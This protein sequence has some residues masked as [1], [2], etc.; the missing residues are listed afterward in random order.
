MIVVGCEC[1]LTVEPACHH[2]GGD[3]ESGQ[4]EADYRSHVA[5]EALEIGEVKL[6]RLTA[7]S[8]SG[9]GKNQAIARYWV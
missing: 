9:A 4:P 3:Q 6:R 7:R 5:K 2:D 1:K 8:A